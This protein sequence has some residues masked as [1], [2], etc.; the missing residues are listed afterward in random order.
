MNIDEYIK[1]VCDQIILG[2]S[3]HKIILFGSYANGTPNEDSD[4]DLLVIMPYDGNELD[5]MAEVRR[6]LS[7]AMPLDVL[8]KTPTQI[9]NR[10]EMEDFFV[11]EIVENGKILYDAGDL[12]MDK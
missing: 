2:F 7:S 3:P 4:I 10:L 8:V 9:A 6:K 11:H 1:K 5:K 12:G